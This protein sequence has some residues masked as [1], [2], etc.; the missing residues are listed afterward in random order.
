ML[1]DIREALDNRDSRR[2]HEG[3]HRLKGSVINFGARTA[4]EAAEKMEHLAR[5]Q[6]LVGAESS[7]EELKQLIEDLSKVLSTLIKGEV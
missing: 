6:D 5:E 1:L 2:L 7:Y 4:F 3:A